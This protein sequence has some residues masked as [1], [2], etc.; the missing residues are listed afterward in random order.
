ME[1][2]DAGPWLCIRY[3]PVALFTLKS[4]LATSSGG[5]VLGI[6]GVQI[7]PGA[8]PFTRIF[9]SARDCASERVNAV[10]APLVEE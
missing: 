8:T 1:T 6:K 2:P 4:A 9:F 10:I 7:G 3:L 5:K